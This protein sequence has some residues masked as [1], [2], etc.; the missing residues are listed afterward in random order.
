MVDSGLANAEL[1]FVHRGGLAGTLSFPSISNYSTEQIED[2]GFTL[3]SF[4]WLP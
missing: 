3:A 1:G 4:A 2:E